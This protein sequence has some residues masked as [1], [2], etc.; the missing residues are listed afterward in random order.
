M[1]LGHEALLF[2]EAD[3]IHR[4]T[5]AYG[6]GPDLEAGIEL[7]IHKSRIQSGVDSRVK[8]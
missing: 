7:R 2:I 8:H 1:R 6:N 3:C 5:T 4:E